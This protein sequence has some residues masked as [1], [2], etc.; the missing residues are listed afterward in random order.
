MTLDR[1][2]QLRSALSRRPRRLPIRFAVAATC[3]TFAI[4]SAAEPS[5][6]TNLLK[7]GSRI[8]FQGDSITDCDRHRDEQTDLGH[9]YVTIIATELSRRHPQHQFVIANR[10]ISGNRVWDL[11]ARWQTDAIDLK[12]D[13]ISILIGVNDT[14][15]EVAPGDFE[16]AYDELLAY[17]VR[18]LPNTRLVLCE[19]FTLIIGPPTPEAEHWRSSVRHCASIVERLAKKY[20]VPFVRFQ[21][22]LD[23]AV[24]RAPAEHWLPD[25]IHPSAAAHE[26]L[27]A[28]W[29]RSVAALDQ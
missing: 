28:E 26:L 4:V 10:G 21:K 15:G 27:A 14:A 20:R 25:G 8:L 18:T 29:I 22:V 9:G 23:D 5:S 17:T 24:K 11:A 7:P 19:P 2:R 16:A 13:V 12:P 6:K 1:R 3:A